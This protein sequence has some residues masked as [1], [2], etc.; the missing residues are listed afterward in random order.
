MAFTVQDFPCN[1]V[2]ENHQALPEEKQI[3]RTCIENT[4]CTQPV[5]GDDDAD[6]DD[7]VSNLR[8][9]TPLTTK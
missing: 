8:R 4:Y 2:R 3:V 5:P 7:L 6:W 9:M 1:I